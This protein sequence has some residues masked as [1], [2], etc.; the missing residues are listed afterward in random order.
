MH[1]GATKARRVLAAL[2]R[3]GW[4]EKRT[5][6]GRA[7]GRGSHRVLERIGWKNFVFAF[8]DGDEIGPPMLSRIAR[9]TGLTP[10]DL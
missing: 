9:D 7:R 10:D 2:K 4:S 3:I 6:A 5:V 8:H 1:W